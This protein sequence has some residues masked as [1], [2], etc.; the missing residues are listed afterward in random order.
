MLGYRRGLLAQVGS[1]FGVILGIV[2]CHVLGSSVA[3]HFIE[4]GDGVD[5]ILLTSVLSYALIFVAAYLTGR[6]LGNLLSGVLQRLHLG[7][8]N[9]IGGAVFTMF[10]Y[11]L[12]YS[13]LL[14]TF[15]GAFPN[16]QLRTDYDSIKR[17]VINLAPDV[18]G[19]QTIGEIYAKFETVVTEGAKGLGGISA[20]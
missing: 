4:D 7:I 17:F 13:L 20:D 10:E 5:T 11:L 18:L 8:F 2:C 19:S 9:R 16:T 3:E 14:N 6:F 1:I 12:V 15:I